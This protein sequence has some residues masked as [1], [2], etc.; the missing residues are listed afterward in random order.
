[1]KRTIYRV[2]LLFL[3]SFLFATVVHA[4]QNNADAAS[5]SGAVED[6]LAR[7]VTAFE[8]LDWTTFR[9][10]FSAN[11]TMFHPAS[12]N[13]RRVDSP[14]EFD[15][16]WHG[17]FNRIKRN[18]GRTSAPYM[19]LNSQDVRIERLTPDVALVT[20]HLADP[21]I[22]GR[23]SLVFQKIDGNWK[24]VHIHASNLPAPE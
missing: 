2:T 11:P 24:I 17:V 23:R 14:I 19:K 5:R 9:D 6:A 1:M 12:P 21:G 7:F 16:A 3:S 22:I 18:S 4:Q 8:N 15:N 13:L 10:C 20:F